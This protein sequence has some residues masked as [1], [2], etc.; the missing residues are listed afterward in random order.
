MSMDMN[1]YFLSK[2]DSVSPVTSG[3]PQGSVLG[4]VMFN[5]F[6]DDM[7]E[8][9]ESFISKFADNTKPGV[10]VDLLE[11]WAMNKRKPWYNRKVAVC[12]VVP[13]KKSWWEDSHDWSAAVDGKMVFRKDRGRRG[14][15]VALYFSEALDS[16]EIEVNDKFECL[17]TCPVDEGKAVSVVYPDF[18]KTFNTVSHGLL[19]EKLAAHSLNRSTLC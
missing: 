3:V 10:C 12:N 16:V 7:D 14:G 15:G 17:W 9:I 18:S 5:I 2:L 1:Y 13:I 8:G 6:I 11:A 19:L 4:P